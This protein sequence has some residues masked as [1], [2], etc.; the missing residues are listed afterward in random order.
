[1]PFCGGPLHRADYQRKPRGGPPDLNEAY[2]VRL[3]LCCGRQGCRR[4]V[5]PPSVRFWGRR[6][7]W[8]AAVVVLTALCQGPGRAAA[9]QRVKAIYNLTRP[10]LA[11]WQRYF[12]E[13]FPSSRCWRGLCGRLMPPVNPHELPGALITR[14]VSANREPFSALVA[15]MKALALGP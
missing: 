4:R 12:H 15:C 2:E 10:T 8:R 11:R 5:C 3:S 14:F 13:E 9:R 7:Y 1:M 6:V